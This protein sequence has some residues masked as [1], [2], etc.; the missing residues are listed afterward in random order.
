VCAGHVVLLVCQA[1]RRFR[2]LP[3]EVGRRSLA[4]VG[5]LIR[6]PSAPQ[7]AS[8]TGRRRQD[9]GARHLE[10]AGL[11]VLPRLALAAALPGVLARHQMAAAHRQAAAVHRQAAQRTDALTHLVRLL[12]EAAPT[13]VTAAGG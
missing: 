13:P 1:H 12:A 2:L 7:L 10:E 6:L 8:P 4:V 5:T 3:V 11:P 9:A